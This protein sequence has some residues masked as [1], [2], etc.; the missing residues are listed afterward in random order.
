MNS[1]KIP[2]ALQTPG[3]VICLILFCYFSYQLLFTPQ[4]W[5]VL[6]YANLM[7]H[8]AG[9]LLFTFTTQFLYVLAGSMFQII[10]PVIF[11]I[12]FYFTKQTFAQIFSIFWIGNNLINVAY[13]IKDATAMKL[14]LAFGGTIHDWNWIL[15]NLG[16][17]HFDQI[18]GNTVL[19]IG[20][21]FLL[22]SIFFCLINILNNLTKTN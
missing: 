21:V 7:I 1:L 4:H 3:K 2:L 9:H 10:F 5:I 22:T 11:L 12:Y 19:A 17:L 6:D 18:I 8:E 13:Y 15:F 16:L 20:T 14:P